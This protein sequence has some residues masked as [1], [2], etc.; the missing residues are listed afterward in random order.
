M[1]GR[2]SHSA[3]MTGAASDTAKSKRDRST[4]AR[5]FLAI[6]WAEPTST[7]EDRPVA[8]RRPDRGGRNA[9]TAGASTNRLANRLDLFRSAEA[10]SDLPTASAGIAQL[11]CFNRRGAL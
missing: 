6:R 4:G 1:D 2:K 9:R 3:A 7:R 11:I 10:D 8:D 5:P